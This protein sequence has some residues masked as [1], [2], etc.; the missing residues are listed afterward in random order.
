M[1]ERS[2]LIGPVGISGRTTTCTWEVPVD[3]ISGQIS[4]RRGV[5]QRRGES[6]ERGVYVL[7]KYFVT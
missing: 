6:K 7:A 3:I 2:V 1:R 5:A 4:G